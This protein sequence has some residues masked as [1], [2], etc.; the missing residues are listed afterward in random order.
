MWGSLQVGQ[1]IKV[2]QNERFPADLILLKSSNSS[3]IA[4]VETTRLDGETNLKHKAAIRDMQDAILSESDAS[5]INGNIYCDHPN[6]FIYNFD[7]LMTIKVKNSA[8]S[9]KY[10]LDYNQL[11]LRGTS[12]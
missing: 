10:T 12:L 2:K 1:V 11:L 4:Y 9:Y 5:Q 6:S 3:G 7:A 8:N